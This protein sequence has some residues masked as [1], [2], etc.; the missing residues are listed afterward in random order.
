MIYG[1]VRQTDTTLAIGPP[2]ARSGTRADSKKSGTQLLSQCLGQSGVLP[3][4]LALKVVEFGAISRNIQWLISIIFES[5]VAHNIMIY[6]IASTTRT[7]LILYTNYLLAI[8]VLWS[9]QWAFCA[10]D[11]FL[12]MLTR[13]WMTRKLLFNSLLGLVL[14]LRVIGMRRAEPEQT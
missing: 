9:Q 3:S 6:S 8:N 5:R 7:A 11:N 13:A 4:G 14:D 12:K 10:Y 1:K 2:P